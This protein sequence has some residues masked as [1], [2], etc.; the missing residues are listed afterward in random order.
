MC[1]EANGIHIGTVGLLFI[2]NLA[3]RLRLQVD[4]TSDCDVGIDGSERKEGG[5]YA[6]VRPLHACLHGLYGLPSASSRPSPPK[7][8]SLFVL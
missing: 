2:I 1:I 6:R 7:S 5:A 4:L 8:P 3:Q